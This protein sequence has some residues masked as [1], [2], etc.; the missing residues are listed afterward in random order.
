MT[1]DYRTT[2]NKAKSILAQKYSQELHNIMKELGYTKKK[3]VTKSEVQTKPEVV[4][5]EKEVVSK[6]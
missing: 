5:I 3:K 2:Y 6:K 4:K 1:N